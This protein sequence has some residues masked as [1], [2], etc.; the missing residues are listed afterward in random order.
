MFF[1]SNLRASIVAVSSLYF[2][3]ENLKGLRFFHTSAD[4]S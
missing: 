2:C 1:F 4:V 3:K